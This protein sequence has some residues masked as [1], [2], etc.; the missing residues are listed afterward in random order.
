M[1]TM[2]AILTI[3]KEEI[4]KAILPNVNMNKKSKRQ[5]SPFTCNAQIVDLIQ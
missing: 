4:N 5:Y 2:L 1:F 3:Q